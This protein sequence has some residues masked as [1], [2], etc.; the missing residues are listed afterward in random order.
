MT[1]RQRLREQSEERLDK[2]VATMLAA[3]NRVSDEHQTDINM[4]DV[5]RLISGTQTKTVRER[6]VV[7]LTNEREVQLEKFFNNQVDAFDDKEKAGE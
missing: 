5:M 7:D 6:L 1:L 2:I 3:C 4:F